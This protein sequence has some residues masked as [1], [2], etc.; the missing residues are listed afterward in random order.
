L[1]V[2]TA[3]VTLEAQNVNCW[4]TANGNRKSMQVRE[5]CTLH[6]RRAVTAISAMDRDLVKAY[7]DCGQK[8]LEIIASMHYNAM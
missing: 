5:R 1:S 4:V 2:L 8:S 3:R 6:V 7:E